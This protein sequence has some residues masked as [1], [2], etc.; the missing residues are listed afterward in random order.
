MNTWEPGRR[1]RNGRSLQE[2]RGQRHHHALRHYYATLVSGRTLTTE[3]A[4]RTLRAQICCGLPADPEH[5]V[6][7]P[8]QVSGPVR[9][10]WLI[11]R[12]LFAVPP[13]DGTV[14]DHPSPDAVADTLQRPT[15]ELGRTALK[16]SLFDLAPGGVCLA[17]TVPR[18]AGGLLHHRF[19]LTGAPRSPG[20]LFSV[21]LSR[22]SPRVGVTHHLVLW[23]PDLPRHLA[24]SRSVTRSPGQPIRSPRIGHG[25]QPHL[26]EDSWD[27]R[28]LPD[29][30]IW[31]DDSPLR[32]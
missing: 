1:A 23:S 28:P 17:A 4:R 26:S 11:G 13:H 6:P 7:A 9:M 21:A 32:L 29:L 5:P 14:G 24:V 12:V 18:R 22:G 27:G 30:V 25:R 31:A 8:A 19:T 20:G 3:R 2:D 15:R 10:G 16:H